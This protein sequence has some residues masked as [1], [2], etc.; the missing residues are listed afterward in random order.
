MPLLRFDLV[1]GRNPKELQTLLDAQRVGDGFT[2]YDDL[3]P[4]QVK[5]LSDA[6]NALSEPLSHL[7]ASVLG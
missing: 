7:T 2:L 6:V 1:E 3:S 4:D 5:E